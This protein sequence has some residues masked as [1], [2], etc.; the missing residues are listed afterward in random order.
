MAVASTIDA[1]IASAQVE[2]RP[3]LEAI[4][5]TVRKAAATAQ[6]R[7]SYGMPAFFLD[8]ALVYFGAFKSHIGFYP[9]VRDPSLQ[10]RIQDKLARRASKR[11]R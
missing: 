7:I 1:Y 11:S 6:E 4:R 10:A 8:G 9:P 3:V 2:V 5:A